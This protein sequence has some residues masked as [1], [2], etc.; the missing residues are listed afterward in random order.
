MSEYTKRL[1]IQPP[2]HYSLRDA[3]RGRVWRSPIV[4]ICREFLGWSV[5]A[6]LFGFLTEHGVLYA[7]GVVSIFLT[8]VI[9]VIGS[10]ATNRKRVQLIQSGQGTT[11]TMEQPKR[12]FLIHEFLRGEREKTFVLPFTYQAE[13]GTLM[14]SRVWVCGCARDYFPRHS[15]SPIAY[16]LTQSNQALPLRLAVMVAPH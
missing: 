4:V 13:D 16:S 10:I 1:P 5:A 12:V 7:C 8:V 14:R 2:R 3:Y 11:A 6:A 15:E 9:M